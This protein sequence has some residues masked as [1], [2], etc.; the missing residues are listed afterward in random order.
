MSTILATVE[1]LENE[2]RE[3]RRYVFSRLAI[4][5]V[6]LGIALTIAFA[7]VSGFTQAGVL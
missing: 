2:T 3:T 7:V 1:K 4:A 6:S 5:G